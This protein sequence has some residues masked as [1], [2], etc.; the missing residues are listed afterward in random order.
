MV[1]P[2]ITKWSRFIY[3]NF[4]HEPIDPDTPTWE[5]PSEGPLSSANGALPWIIFSRDRKVFEKSFPLLIISRIEPTMPFLYLMTGGFSS[6]IF[7]PGW[8]FQIWKKAED[9]LSRWHYRLGIFAV[10]VLCNGSVK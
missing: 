1:E 5:F 9:L 7:F 4:H 8:T 6:R 2:W 10:I 3:S